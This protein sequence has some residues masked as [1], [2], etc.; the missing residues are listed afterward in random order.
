MKNQLNNEQIQF[1]QNNGFIVIEDFLSQ[2]ELDH[3]RIAVT[4]AVE[5][6]GGIK[7]PGKI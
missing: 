3:W 4:T 1:Y 5:E 7:Y 2:E 6:R